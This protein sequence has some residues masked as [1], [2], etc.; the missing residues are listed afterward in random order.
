VSTRQKTLLV[1]DADE[2]ARESF[3]DALREDYRVV[4][5][6]SA[7]GALALLIR[8]E[9]DVALVD[10]RQP[11]I[12]GF[13][14]LRILRENYP[15]AEII[16]TSAAADVASAVEAMNLGAFHFVT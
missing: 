5:A 7:E 11:G 6:A 14:L 13:E 4:R 10:V 9:V 1:V 12:S 3:H 15:G 2:V 16:M 8:D